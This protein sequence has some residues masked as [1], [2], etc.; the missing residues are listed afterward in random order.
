[1]FSCVLQAHASATVLNKAGN[2]VPCG[3]P[4]ELCVSGFLVTDGGYW[5]Q[6]DKSVEA[7]DSLGWMHTGDLA[8]I[9]E[10]GFAN[11]V[12]RLKELIIRGG[13]PITRNCQVT[14]AS[15]T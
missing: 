11:I 1:M 8:V 10:N 14:R 5:R 4:G 12:G 3:I 6:P 9:D 15:I 2:I 7:V 13:G